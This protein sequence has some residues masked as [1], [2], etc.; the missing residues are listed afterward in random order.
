MKCDHRLWGEADGLV[1]DG[2]GH[3]FGHTYQAGAGNDDE[4]M[5]DQ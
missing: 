1:C 4:Q 5:E 3:P 2:K